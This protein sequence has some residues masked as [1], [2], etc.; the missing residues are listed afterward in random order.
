MYDRI[1][2]PIDGSVPSQRGLREAVALARSLGSTIVLLHVIDDFPKRLEL[3]SA[4]VYEQSLERMRRRGQELLDQARASVAEA[5][6]AAETTLRE[7][8]METIADAVLEHARTRR[9]SL[10]VMGTHGRR[11][12]RRL[13][14]GSD[15][16]LVL[17][18]SPVPVL[19]VRRD[20]DNT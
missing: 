4:E 11:G 18:A 13:A 3:A 8:D 1:L 16:E 14:M 15:A 10:I 19:L 2:V 9:C 20:D 12:M 5:G 7:I 6:V 17:R